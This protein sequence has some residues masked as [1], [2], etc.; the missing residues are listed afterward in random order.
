[1]S[2][3]TFEQLTELHEQARGGQVTKENLQAF[4]RNPDKILTDKIPTDTLSI[5]VPIDIVITV[6]PTELVACDKFKM[7]G[8]VRIYRLWSE[9][10]Q[11]FLGKVEKLA[12]V[13]KTTLSCTVLLKHAVDEEII[14]A[15]GGEAKAETSLAEI[16]DLLQK[17]PNGERG[18]LLTDSSANIF[19]V[20]D[21]DEVLRTVNV[22]WGNSGWRVVA[23]LIGDPAGW[24]PG[25]QV[26]FRNC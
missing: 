20:K 25:G 14:T 3:P 22:Y 8:D 7:N 23:G 4:L 2:N 19:Y 6:R 15:L 21:R 16:W 26:I 1:M 18:V 10:E 9:F 24:L 13:A 12:E 11:W 5:L 17:Q